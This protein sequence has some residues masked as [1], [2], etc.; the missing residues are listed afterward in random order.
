MQS[1]SLHSRNP[2][3][4]HAKPAVRNDICKKALRVLRDSVVNS[5]K[6]ASPKRGLRI[7]EE[8]TG[9]LES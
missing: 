3:D 6:E 9:S 8:A 1:S 2:N 4:S 7:Q 5:K